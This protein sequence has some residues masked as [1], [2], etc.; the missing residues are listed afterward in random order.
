ML[1]LVAKPGARQPRGTTGGGNTGMT[2]RGIMR[3]TPQRGTRVA[4]GLLAAFGLI[5]AGCGD[6]DDD[7]DTTTPAASE[8]PSTEAPST[9]AP[10]TE[11]PSTE[12][13]TTE[14]PEDSEAP[15]TTTSDTEEGSGTFLAR[16]SDG[17][18]WD[19]EG[20]NAELIE[21][22]GEYPTVEGNTTQGI[23]GT[24]I[25]L[26][27]NV[28]ATIQ[29]VPTFGDGLCDGAQARLDRANRD[30][31]LPYTFE[32]VAATDTGA[33]AAKTVADATEAVFDH[34][35][36]AAFMTYSGALPSN[37]FEEN[38][39][40]YF[41]DFG[42]CGQAS[43]FGFNISFQ[44]LQCPAVLTETDGAKTT[45]NSAI[46]TAFA[47]LVGNTAFR[48]AAMGVSIP[49]IVTY[50][51]N[52]V[53]QFEQQGVDVVY[54][55]NLLPPTSGEAVDLNPYVIPIIDA[56]PEVLGIFSTDPL[57]TARYYGALK[58]AGYTGKA[59]L[60]VLASML[61]NEQTAEQLDGASGTNQGWGYDDGSDAWN[62]VREDAE[63][64]G[65]PLPL[66]SGFYRGW[67]IADEF[68][69][70]MNDFL[71]TGEELTTENL[72]NFMND[73]WSYAGF[74]NVVAPTI[75]P[76]GKYGASPCAAISKVSAADKAELPDQDLTCGEV[77]FQDATG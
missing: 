40:P 69:S 48:Y 16:P 19:M 34:Q 76:Y 12:A 20:T 54:S 63:L 23:N 38:H 37:P 26:A 24:E 3:R 68:L 28:A 17:P 64:A 1:R 8:A 59:S 13:P 10:S 18:T 55:E 60:Q 6:D 43:Q 30:G 67:G 44:I 29:G 50:Q 31:E 70:G 2:T 53:A 74:G 7:A 52:F 25:S 51:Q 4:I 77:F 57:L 21:V 36:F 27:C 58:D 65:A 5:A 56:D 15:D 71:A 47:E 9:E 41:G 11:A 39:I 42:A 49:G 32:I 22:V 61:Q 66:Q 35:V 73:G 72:V 33:D 62:T 75:Y 45:Y 14:A 46:Q